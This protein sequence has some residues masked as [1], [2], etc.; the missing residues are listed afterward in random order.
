MKTPSKQELLRKIDAL[1][2]CDKT[3]IRD[4]VAE[5]TG[6]DLTPEPTY[7]RGQRFQYTGRRT[8][9]LANGGNGKIVAVNLTTGD[10]RG[11]PAPVANINKIT[12]EELVTI[13]RTRYPYAIKLLDK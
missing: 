1:S 7:K 10:R 8:Y 6:I 3:S 9:I 13:F 2:V 11:L 5:I 12:Q 4:L